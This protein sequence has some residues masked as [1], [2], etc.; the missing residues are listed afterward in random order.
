MQK[1]EGRFYITID[2]DD[3]NKVNFDEVMETSAETLRYSVDQSQV[4][5]K[6]IPPQ[7][8]AYPVS[9]RTINSKSA[10]YQWEA[11][12]ELMATPEWTDPNI[13]P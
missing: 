8:Q 2:A 12:I 5:L 11:F 4:T 13:E 1:F 9:L 7:G 3:V 10:R 6:F